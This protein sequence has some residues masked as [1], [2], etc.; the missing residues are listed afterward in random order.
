[1]HFGRGSDAAERAKEAELVDCLSAHAEA[2]EHLYLLGDVFD[3]YIEYAH[4][5]PKGFVRF[6][7]ELARWADRGVPVTYLV[8]NH[9]PWHRDHFARELGVRLVTGDAWAA[10]H[11]GRRL[12]LAHGDAPAATGTTRTL[13]QWLRHPVPVWL[14]RTLLPADTGLRLAE[15][16]N[17]RFG[18]HAPDPETDRLLEAHARRL[19][20]T[21]AADGVV[22]GHSHQPALQV[23]PEGA[24]LNTGCWHNRRTLG[25]L[26]ANGLHLL[27]WNGTRTVHIEASR[28]PE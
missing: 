8:G 9:D 13:R 10:T 28:L 17:R 5:V 25:R 4:L 23:W 22:M 6:Q 21:T 1:M 14:Y 16:V 2:A 7:A 19:L 12:H 26:D 24:Y 27:R 3:A 15:W 18:H 20:Q 11:A